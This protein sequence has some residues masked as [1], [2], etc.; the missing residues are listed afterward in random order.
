[1]TSRRQ[2]RV[3]ELLHEELSLLLQRETND[4]RFSRVTVTYVEVSADLGAAKVYVTVLGEQSEQQAALEALDHA[5]GYLRHELGTRLR[6]R[7]IPRLTFE[8]DEA[9]ERGSRVL[10]LLADLEAADQSR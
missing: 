4:P 5:A 9:V 3:G 8:L 1:M 7:R 10:E 2:K 6:L